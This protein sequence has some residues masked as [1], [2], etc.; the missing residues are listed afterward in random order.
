MNS[1]VRTLAYRF[2]HLNRWPGGAA[3]ANGCFGLDSRRKIQAMPLPVFQPGL[4]S[5]LP[6]ITSRANSRVKQLR[7]AFAGHARLSGGLIAIEG[8]TMLQEALRR[9]LPIKTIFLCQRASTPEWLPRS[10]ELIEL[11]DEVFSSVVDTQ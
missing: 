8:E 9:G 10:V 3:G 2:R 6:V 5:S 11:T 1:A 7:A 4:Q